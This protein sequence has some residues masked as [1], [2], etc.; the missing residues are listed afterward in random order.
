[1]KCMG[2]GKGKQNRA[3]L[4]VSRKLR[5]SDKLDTAWLVGDFQP[6]ADAATK[7]FYKSF[8]GLKPIP[9]SSQM[10]A[11]L[12]TVIGRANSQLIKLGMA[13]LQSEKLIVSPPVDKQTLSLKKGKLSTRKSGTEG[14]VSF[15]L[16]NDPTR[17]TVN[18]K[19]FYSSSFEE[20]NEAMEYF[21]VYDVEDLFLKDVYIHDRK[22]NEEIVS[23]VMTNRKLIELSGTIAHE[24]FHFRLREK[25]KEASREAGVF[26]DATSLKQVKIN[27]VCEESIARFVGHLAEETSS[28]SYFHINGTLKEG[29]FLPYAEMKQSHNYRDAHYMAVALHFM[30]EE[31]R[32]FVGK[33][34]TPY[35]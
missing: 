14:T 11:V 2:A 24:M 19:I 32:G 13:P 8:T 5:S 35:A 9:G 34:P 29:K 22:D 28:E 16:R 6:A 25:V 21:P 15:S 23:L 31:R 4:S 7:L 1:M 27:A 17:I 20:V 3:Q 30:P 33:R 12:Q 10:N 18:P 26:M